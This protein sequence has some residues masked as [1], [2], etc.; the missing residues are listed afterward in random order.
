MV[1]RAALEMQCTARYRGFESLPLR[2]LDNSLCSGAGDRAWDRARRAGGMR[3]P[4]STERG[5]YSRRWA[6]RWASLA[7]AEGQPI[8]PS[9]P[10]RIKVNNREFLRLAAAVYADSNKVSDNL[11]PGRVSTAC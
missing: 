3:I 10:A 2:Q 8:P 9:P 6:A 11:Y 7:M 4:G 5:L 1:D